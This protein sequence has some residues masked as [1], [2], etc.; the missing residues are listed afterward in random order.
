MSHSHNL[1]LGIPK[2][3]SSRDITTVKY[4]YIIGSSIAY[5]AA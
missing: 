2:V 1:K 4:V 5:L 3:L